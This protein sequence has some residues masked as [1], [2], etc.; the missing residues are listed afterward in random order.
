M[1]NSCSV[2]VRFVVYQHIPSRF[3]CSCCLR[4]SYSFM[5][6]NMETG[7]KRNRE[8]E[9]A[10]VVVVHTSCY[11]NY[12]VCV[13]T[14]FFD[15]IRSSRE[16]P[17]GLSYPETRFLA[18]T[19]SMAEFNSFFS[20]PHRNSTIAIHHLSTVEIYF[21]ASQKKKESL[22]KPQQ[23]VTRVKNHRSV[24]INLDSVYIIFSHRKISVNTV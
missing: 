14:P 7:R 4:P 23:F 1:D 6:C 12:P 3:D 10:V 19:V 8:I 11:L 16:Q 5:P 15:F 17:F 18:H 22:A 21:F 13:S 9:N 24:S 2:R 20:F